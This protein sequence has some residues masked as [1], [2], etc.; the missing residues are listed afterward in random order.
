MVFMAGGEW[1]VISGQSWSVIG[2]Q[3]SVR[4]VPGWHRRLRACAGTTT[5]DGVWVIGVFGFQCRGGG[6]GRRV[7]RRAKGGGPVR[8][9]CYFYFS[10]PYFEEG[11]RTKTVQ[12][13]KLFGE[14]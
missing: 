4:C 3:R 11:G 9:D 6:R 13:S 8:F 12:P 2:D 7:R 14:F 1:V 5:G 10:C